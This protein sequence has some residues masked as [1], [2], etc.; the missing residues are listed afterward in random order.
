MRQYETMYVLRPELDPD[1]RSALVTKFQ[2]VVTQNGGRITQ[3]QEIGKRRLAYEI[4]GAREGDYVLMQYE[5]S[6]MLVKE[7][8]R[9]FKITDGVMRYLT[10]RIG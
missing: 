2:H 4:E 6:T 8:E 3:L 1:A 5:G 7:L 9:T 10:V